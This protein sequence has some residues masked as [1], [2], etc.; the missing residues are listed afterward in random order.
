V[1]ASLLEG[2]PE[3]D[4]EREPLLRVIEAA[5]RI[6]SMASGILD[7]ERKDERGIDL[8]GLIDRVVG[9]LRHVAVQRGVRLELA[10]A[11]NLWVDGDSQELSRL[12]TNL[13]SNAFKYAPKDTRVGLSLAVDGQHVVCKVRD[14]GPGIP[15]GMEESVF[16][17]GQQAPGAAAGHGLGL[18]HLPAHRHRTWGHDP[19]SQPS[20]WWCPAH[21][22]A[23]PPRA[24]LGQPAG[25]GGTRLVDGSLPA[26]EATA[27][28]S[29]PTMPSKLA[30]PLP[31][32][33][34]PR[35]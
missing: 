7:E 15:A 16:G 30:T 4:P 25:R 11:P 8:S 28:P 22:Q 23:A 26:P 9:L 12:V 27:M 29:E 3:T 24:R 6:R 14:Q 35:L 1:I 5:Q 19:G 31:C 13:V 2:K 10:I 17:R 33:A 18:V 21:L 20:P 34:V 32:T